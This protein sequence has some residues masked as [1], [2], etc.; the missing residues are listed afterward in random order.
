MNN[1]H[2]ASQSISSAPILD[3]SGGTFQLS[4]G[5]E[6]LPE[7]RA[8]TVVTL[9][10]A[11][12]G[13]ELWRIVW[14]G[15][16][17]ALV[18]YQGDKE[19]WRSE[20]KVSLT[21]ASLRLTGPFDVVAQQ[22]VSHNERKALFPGYRAPTGAVARAVRALKAGGASPAAAAR[23]IFTLARWFLMFMGLVLLVTMCSQ[24]RARSSGDLP[25][26]SHPVS[27]A[28]AAPVSQSQL[29][30]ELRDRTLGDSLSPTEMQVVANATREMG[31]QMRPSGQPFVIFSDPNCPSCKDLEPK[32]SQVDP[33][34]VPVIVPVSFKDGSE[35]AVKR[36]LCAKDT[37]SAWSAAIGGYEPVGDAKSDGSCAGGAEKA[38][39]ANGAFVALNFTGTPT[40]VSAT[41]KV[42][43]GSGSLDDINKWLIAN[44]GLKADVAAR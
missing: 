44:G 14:N 42:V 40:L 31:I 38:V 4:Y 19:L 30:P 16:A 7:E 22:F 10:L 41:G 26:G 3:L 33:R 43:A 21:L 9:L 5:P 37:V 2:P 12:R 32:L 29:P 8:E 34:F 20:M 15:P 35:E 11:T 36:V 1:P 24:W 23:S 13:V 27:A 18:L 6:P 25:P 28:P 17:S 39:K